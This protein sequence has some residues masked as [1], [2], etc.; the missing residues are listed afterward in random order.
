MKEIEKTNKIGFNLNH[1]NLDHGICQTGGE[2]YHHG[3]TTLDFENR[4]I[5]VY[6]HK[7]FPTL[8]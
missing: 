2:D 1:E 6:S 3:K 4:D 8:M 7:E 5:F